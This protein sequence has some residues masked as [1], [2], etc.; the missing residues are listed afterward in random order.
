MGHGALAGVDA[1][2]A[3]A[4]SSPDPTHRSHPA[5][6]PCPWSHA[7]IFAHFEAQGLKEDPTILFVGEPEI[8]EMKMEGS[9]PLLIVQFHCQQIKCTRDKFGNVVEGSPD[10]IQRVFY[11]WGLTQEKQGY[12][13]TDG[14]YMPPRWVIRDMLW[15]SVLALV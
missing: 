3:L 2:R 15:Q 10:S 12:V 1:P 11:F 6:A 5:L 4:C 7:G 13:R 9:D 14:K 8:V